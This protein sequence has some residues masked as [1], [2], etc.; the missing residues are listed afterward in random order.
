MAKLYKGILG[1]PTGKLGDKVY[2]SWKNVDVVKN[3]PKKST[4]EPTQLQIEQREKFGL[5]NA[6]FSVIYEIIFIGFIEHSRKMTQSNAAM[7][8][9]TGVVTGAYPNHKIN[10]SEVLVSLGSLYEPLHPQLKCKKNGMMLLTWNDKQFDAR[11]ERVCFLFY[12]E[13]SNHS[14]VI[15]DDVFPNDGRLIFFKHPEEQKD[16]FH[17]WMFFRSANGKKASASVYLGK[18]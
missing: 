17:V 11:A 15:T 7:K 13:T 1:P 10:Y 12:N 9:N 16:I 6:F 8:L 14:Y 4:K 3:A 2:C 18:N 5:L